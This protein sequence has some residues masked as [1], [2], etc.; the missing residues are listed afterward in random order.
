MSDDPP[1]SSAHQ[2]ELALDALVA[3]AAR[4][5]AADRL[6]PAAGEP[7]L[8]AVAEAAADLIGVT[9]ASVALHDP[10][11]DRL[12]FRAAAGPQGTWGHRVE[13]RGARG[14]RRLRL[15][16]RAAHRGRRRR[17]RPALR[18]HDRRTDRV[19]AAEVVGGAARRRGRDDRGV[20]VARS[21]RRYAVRPDRHRGRHAD[22]GRH[23][24]CCA[25]EQGRSRGGGI[26]RRPSWRRS[27]TPRAS[28]WTVTQ[29]RS[30]S[31]TSSSA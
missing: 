21:A 31:R 23:D 22:G 28:A 9:A 19:R 17:G 29:S 6:V 30:S 10:A 18:A 20:G 4:L 2:R 16:D 12:I 27:P 8:H 25:C 1:G 7:A 26:A 5:A 15:L 24:G 3:V 13:H 11:T 14:H